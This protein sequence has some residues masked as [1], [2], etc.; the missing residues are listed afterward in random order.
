MATPGRTPKPFVGSSSYLE[1]TFPT[2][3]FSDP[4]PALWGSRQEP[5]VRSALAAAPVVGER[6]AAAVLVA[7]R[8]KPPVLVM[9]SP[10][11]PSLD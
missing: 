1:A 2:W 8:V 3:I 11:G 10:R 6:L 9:V 5:A 4:D 7:A